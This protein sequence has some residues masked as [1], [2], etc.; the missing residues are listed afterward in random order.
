[1][2]ILLCENECALSS[3]LITFTILIIF[4]TTTITNC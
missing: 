2:L 1:V 3:T 4:S